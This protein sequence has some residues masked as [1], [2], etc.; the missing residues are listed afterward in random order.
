MFHRNALLS[1]SGGICIYMYIIIVKKEKKR[2]RLEDLAF[3]LLQTYFHIVR[4]KHCR[5]ICSVLIQANTH[6]MRLPAVYF[7]ICTH[8][9]YLEHFFFF[10]LI[11]T[12]SFFFLEVAAVATLHFSGTLADDPI[13]WAVYTDC[14]EKTKR[15]YI[16]W[17][18]K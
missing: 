15:I 6:W 18:I 16:K 9:I 10:R 7:S 12:P 17:C 14:K 2:R 8:W 4:M 13:K 1:V 5:R 11:K 3:I